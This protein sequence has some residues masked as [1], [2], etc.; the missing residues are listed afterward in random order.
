MRQM[1]IGSHL[2]PF[3]QQAV[4]TSDGVSDFVVAVIFPETILVWCVAHVVGERHK[5]ATRFDG[6][7]AVGDKGVQKFHCLCVAEQILR[8]HQVEF[9]VQ[10]LR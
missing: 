2:G 8:R 7:E 4:G 10:L 5:G 1:C 6:G 9:P 3:R